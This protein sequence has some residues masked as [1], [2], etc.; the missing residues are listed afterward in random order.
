MSSPYQDKDDPKEHS[1]E[2]RKMGNSVCGTGNPVKEFKCSVS[3]D[4]PFCLD[5]EKKIKVDAGVGNIIP[6]A[7][8][9]PNT[10]PEA[11]ITL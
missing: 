9:K 2:M 7:N 10:E 1:S 3:N 5:G 6:K 4:K 11:P 8:N